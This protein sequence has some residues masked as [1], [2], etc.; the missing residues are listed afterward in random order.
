MNKITIS[1]IIVLITSSVAI[2][3]ENSCF[4]FTWEGDS[5]SGRYHPK[6]SINVAVSV[7]DLPHQFTMQL[8]LGAV[9]TNLYGNSFQPYMEEYP[10][11]KEKIDSSKTFFIQNQKNPMFVDMSLSMGDQKF[12]HIDIGLF[13][14]FGALISADSVKTKS[15]KHIGTIAP[16][17]FQNKIL[18]IDYP[19]NRICLADK[20]PK[21]FKDLNFQDL[22][23][24]GGRVMIPFE[25][26][27]R[28][29]MLMFDTGS[30]MFS[31]LTTK[32]NSVLV[33]DGKVVDSLSVN[34]WGTEIPVYGS[35]L[36]ADVKLGGK[37]LP[38][39]LVYYLDNP[40]FDAGFKQIGIWGI[41]GNAYFLNS[42]VIIDYRSQKIAIK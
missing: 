15:V 31:L 8:D 16:D 42:T 5:I 25:I 3:Q 38:P 14:G 13:K 34:S 7:D 28:K 11:L 18:V 6:L 17:I 37:S 22:V 19:N 33:T 39:A 21:E 2:G 35:N 10:S 29:E 40:Q 41:T 1:L 4:D 36:T 23:L 12:D 20:L 27:D 26:N 9:R 24:E 30:S 32:N